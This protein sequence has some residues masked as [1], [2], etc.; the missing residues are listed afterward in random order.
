[1]RAAVSTEKSEQSAS[2]CVLGVPPAPQ[3]ESL[4]PAIST[5]T[6]RLTREQDFRQST[7]VL[8]GST[9]HGAATFEGGGR[10]STQYR[11]TRYA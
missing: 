8:T 11:R 1:M 9:P 4:S 10:K 2:F 3:R 5:R 6:K 7:F